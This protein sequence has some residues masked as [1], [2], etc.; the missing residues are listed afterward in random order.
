MIFLNRQE[1]RI[2]ILLSVVL[3]L[4]I[5]VLLVKRLQPGWFMQISMGKP[6]FDV[7]TDQKSPRLTGSEPIKT[8]YSR[9]VNQPD[10]KAMANTPSEHKAS[11]QIPEKSGSPSQPKGKININI[12]TQEE[13]ESL[14]RIGPVLASRIIEYRQEYGS[15]KDIRELKNV[16]GIGDKTLQNVE[17]YVT[18]GNSN[19]SD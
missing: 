5:G 6:D 17:E 2:V 4:S 15:F 16:R 9:Q 7:E 14:P 11:N 1:Q 18:T 10:A 12:A 13:L 19:G 3:L 8:E